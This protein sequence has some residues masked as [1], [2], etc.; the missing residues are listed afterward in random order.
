MVLGNN[1]VYEQVNA[2]DPWACG[3]EPTGVPYP[4]EWTMVRLCD[5]LSRPNINEDVE[6]LYDHKLLTK[7]RP[8]PQ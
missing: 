4:H 6:K 3:F 1:K 7:K 2:L 5:E 8:L